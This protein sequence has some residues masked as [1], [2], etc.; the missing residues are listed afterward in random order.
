MS[1]PKT[2]AATAA[3]GRGGGGIIETL[4]DMPG[5]TR[6]ALL[7][8]FINRIG[9]FVQAFMVLFLAHRG[10]TAAAAGLA[11]GAY[12]L[13]G[14]AGTVI[15]G[16]LSDRLGSRVTIAGG[17][18]GASVMTVSLTVLPTVEAIAAAAFLGGA[19]TLVSRPAITALLLRSV[20]PERQVMVQAMYR[21]ALNS[22][23]AIGP[24]LAAWLSTIDWNLVFYL[25]AVAAVLYAVI[26]YSLFP[27]RSEE[28][29]AAARIGPARP[30]DRAGSLAVFR[31]L[32]YAGYLL[33]M[34]AN[35]VV[36]IQVVVVLPLMVAAAGLATWVYSVP[37]TCA[38]VIVVASELLVTKVTQRWTLWVAVLVGWL[39]LVAGR[40]LYG[41]FD[42]V[43]DSALVVVLGVLVLASAVSAVGQVVG[44]PSAFAYPARVASPERLGS[45]IGSAQGAF[46]VGY[47]VGPVVGTALYLWIGA[48]FWA[49][50]P[51]VGVLMAGVLVWSMRPAEAAP[52]R[53]ADP[54]EPVPVVTPAPA[55]PASGPSG[56]S[57]ASG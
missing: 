43:S 37:I 25:D 12:M 15:G 16:W 34:F 57:R 56:G 33:L 50:I 18:A 47:T 28:L 13:G 39:V 6:V 48:A 14:L 24:L 5:Y 20:P 10:F 26:A 42:M 38:A 32:R 41:L 3:A 8:V 31:D 21:T 49:L 46:Q 30:A 36:H 55:T 35:G 29:A 51:A 45:Y 2:T 4:R 19:L 9:T 17:V 7:G 27:R 53:A 52:A 40:G 54:P 11:L 23:A 22:G 1:G 44:G